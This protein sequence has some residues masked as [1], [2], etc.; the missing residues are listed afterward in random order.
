[1]A[2]AGLA[3]TQRRGRQNENGGLRFA[4]TDGLRFVGN[5]GF[6]AWRGKVTTFRRRAWLAR[7]V[8]PE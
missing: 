5:G 3:V 6:A 7:L 2:L 1:M 8:V 4:G